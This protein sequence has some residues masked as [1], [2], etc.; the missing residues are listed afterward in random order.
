MLKKKLAQRLEAR[1]K[2]LLDSYDD[3]LKEVIAKSPNKIAAKLRKAA[4]LHKRA[5]AIDEFK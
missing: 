4:I 2:T 1:E 3:R 5:Q